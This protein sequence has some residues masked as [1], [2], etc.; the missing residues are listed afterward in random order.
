MAKFAG[1]DESNQMMSF[2]KNEA[3]QQPEDFG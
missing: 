1:L 3:E 2:T